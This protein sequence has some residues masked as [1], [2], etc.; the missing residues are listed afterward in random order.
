VYV[1]APPGDSHRLFVVEQGGTIRLVK[2][3]VV[4]S[5]PFLDISSLVTNGWAVSSDPEQG[6]LSMAFAPDYATSHRFYVYYTSK[7]CPNPPGCT[8]V[9]ATY[10]ADPSGDTATTPGTVILSMP[11][12][13]DVNHNGGQLQ[14]GPDGDLYISTGDGGD[15]NDTHHNAQDKSNL[16]GKVLRIS[17]GPTSYSIPAGNPFVGSECSSGS[18]GGS[19]CP[20]IWSYG[21]R[22]P[23]RFSFD[24]LTGDLVIGDV[25]QDNWEEIDFAHPGQN[26]GANYGWPCF[27]GD[28]TNSAADPG[29]CSGVTTGNTVAP[30][31]EY[32]HCSASVFC[33]SG[34]I[35]GYV[36]RDPAIP[37]LY[38]RYIYGDLSTSGSKGLRS[39][40]LGQPSAS[41]DASVALNVSGLSGFGEDAGG[42]VYAESVNN[43]GVWR[44]APAGSTSPGPCPVTAVTPPPSTGKDSTPA[45]LKITRSRKQHVLKTH[46]I[47]I[48]VSSNE[49]AAITARGRINIPGAAKVFRT[50]TSTRKCF[51]GKKVTLRL[52]LSKKTLGKIRRAL[53]HRKFLT[54]TITVTSKDASGNLSKA[55]HTSVRLVR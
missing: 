49:L 51:G 39:I 52:R 35:G 45:R 40:V 6:L 29:E 11:H 54:A 14:F 3:G 1:A 42:C 36:V 27:E 17:P 41:G 5:T 2:D 19:A 18:N 34:I 26:A 32:P 37:E 47:K 46:Y 23:W 13:G 22:N 10:T 20:E 24:R 21:L 28:H 43:G 9:V 31:F 7:S 53:R 8:N 48:T 33:G 4:Q 12:P 16:L 55:K 15:G 30:V 50:H 44:I 38:G 25:G